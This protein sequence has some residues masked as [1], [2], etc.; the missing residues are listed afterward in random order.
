MRKLHGII[1]RSIVEAC[2]ERPTS[3]KAIA[4]ALKNHANNIWQHMRL[5]CKRGLLERVSKGCY[6]ATEMGKA[7]L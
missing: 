7:S 2:S 6:V 4:T 3:A 5:L 1:S